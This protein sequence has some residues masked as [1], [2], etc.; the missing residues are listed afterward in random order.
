VLVGVAAAVYVLLN[1]DDGVDSAKKENIA[2]TSETFDDGDPLLPTISFTDDG[3]SQ[4]TYTF[5]A[6]SAIRVD[7]QSSMDLQFSSDDH[8]THKEHPELNMKV[9]GP[10]EAGTFTPPGKGTYRFHDHI[11]DEFTG[12]LV[13][14]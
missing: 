14:E 2:P 8:P 3:F 12:T 10:G 9:L 6:G 4:A 5:P 7:N 11:N 13:I 1:K